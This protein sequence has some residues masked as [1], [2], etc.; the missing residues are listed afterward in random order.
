MS[1][2]ETEI[3]VH[4][5][6]VPKPITGSALRRSFS[7]LCYSSH[8]IEFYRPGLAKDMASCWQVLWSWQGFP[9]PALLN[10]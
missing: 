8:T 2:G 6:A 7:Q 5:L 10:G 9:M 3:L 4:P 1:R